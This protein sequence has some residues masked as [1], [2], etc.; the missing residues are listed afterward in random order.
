[1]SE[2]QDYHDE[3]SSNAPKLRTRAG[4]LS[5]LQITFAM[6]IAFG[7]ILAINFS[8]RIAS[9]RPLTEMYD[10]VQSEV[11]RLRA[12]Q[13]TLIAI[14]DYSD[15]DA[16]VEQ[17]A[18]R[19]GKMIRDN[20]VLVVPVPQAGGGA[21]AAQPTPAPMPTVPVQ[22]TDPQPENWTLWWELFFDS[23]PPLG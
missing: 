11:E 10:E 6:I 16:Y 12:Q 1:M 21:V 17:W 8:S 18:R 19:E 3:N 20:E 7:L 22:T 4:Q 2:V 14:R 5:G 23:P 13:A 15:S 9:G